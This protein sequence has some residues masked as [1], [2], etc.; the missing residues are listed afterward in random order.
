[1]SLGDPSLPNAPQSFTTNGGVISFNLGAASGGGISAFAPV[2]FN[3]NGG[4]L[5]GLTSGAFNFEVNS[6]VTASPSLTLPMIR[7][8]IT[9]GVLMSRND[10]GKALELIY[11]DGRASSGAVSVTSPDSSCSTDLGDCLKVNPL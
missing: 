3:L 4:S 5:V 9:S 8:G 2:T 11:S 6:G 1:M 10:L 7:E